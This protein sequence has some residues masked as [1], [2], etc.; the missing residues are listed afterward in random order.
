MVTIDGL[1][2]MPTKQLLG[3]LRALQRCEES[4]SLSDHEP[5]EPL[6]TGIL[7][8]RTPEWRQA[9]DEVKQVLATREHVPSALERADRRA[10]QSL[11]RDTRR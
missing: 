9:Q 3:R 8:K 5:G 10:H 6:P 7:F 4:E 1:R 11:K 2:D